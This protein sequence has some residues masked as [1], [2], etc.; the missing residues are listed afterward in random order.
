MLISVCHSEM[1]E[2]T[3]IFT[4][5]AQ[6]VPL[7]NIYLSHSFVLFFLE[8]GYIAHFL[9]DFNPFTTRAVK[10]GQPEMSHYS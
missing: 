2:A 5:K 3:G 9:E 6:P 10:S 4:L 8:T 7:G 1:G